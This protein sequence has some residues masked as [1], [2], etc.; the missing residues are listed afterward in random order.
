VKAD[1]ARHAHHT[2]VADLAPNDDSSGNANYNHSDQIPDLLPG[3]NRSDI[4][5]NYSWNPGSFYQF[6]V[7]TMRAGGFA[8]ELENPVSRGTR[9]HV[10]DTVNDAVNA[11]SRR[12]T[13]EH[14]IYQAV[15]ASIVSNASHPAL[16]MKTMKESEKLKNYINNVTKTKCSPTIIDRIAERVVAN[17]ES[18]LQKRKTLGNMDNM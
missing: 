5:C 12:E 2:H 16:S 9:A 13:E 10:N 15:V 3:C 1:E 8:D 6:P 11:D 18:I 4:A 17:A 7:S 14:E